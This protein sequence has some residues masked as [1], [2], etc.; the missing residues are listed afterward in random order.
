MVK[1]TADELRRIMDHK[2]NIHN[3]SVIAHVEYGKSTLTDSLV[4]AA[5]IIAQEVA[6][7]VRMTDTRADEAERVALRITDGALV[8]VDRVE[9]VCVQTET[10][11][12]Q[13]LGERIRPVLTINK[14]D[15]CFLELQVYPEKATAAFSAGLHG[16]AF[17][18]TNF[19]KMYASKFGVDESKMMERLWGENF[20]DP[21]TKKWTTKNTGSP[22]CKRGFVQFCYEPIK[23]IINTCMN[24]QK[25]KLWHYEV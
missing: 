4:A 13:A 25:D 24:D 10:V 14:M 11:L 22:T 9:G 18:L 5:G 6:G 7:D 19:A 20:F 2:H 21:A 16:W 8:V 3:M 12:R 15:R 23:Q 1:F 17:T